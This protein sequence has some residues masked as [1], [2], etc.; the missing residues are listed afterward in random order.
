MPQFIIEPGFSE[1]DG[2]AIV[3]LL[4]QYEA[5]LGVSLCFQG[6]EAELAGL[7][8]AYAPPRGQML[9]A[10]APD[11]GRLIGLVALRSVPGAPDLCEMKRLYVSPSARALGLGRALALAI[12]EEARRLG[13]A[14]MCLDTLPGMSEAQALYRSLGFG[15][16][17]ISRPETGVSR[18]ETGVSRPETGVSRSETGASRSEPTVLLFERELARP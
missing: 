16:T 15:Q 5:G 18:P 17:G 8:G 11:D 1:R 13:Y 6:F 7:P 12:M 9:L 10:R 2:G 14:R 3:A 4:R